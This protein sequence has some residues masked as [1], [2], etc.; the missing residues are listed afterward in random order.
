MAGPMADVAS[1]FPLDRQG[2]EDQ[3][4]RRPARRS[5]PA[6]VAD[7]LIDAVLAGRYL[8]G[9]TLPPERQL[10]EQ[11]GINRTSLRHAIARVEQAGL[12]EARQGVGTVVCD[13]LSASDNAIVLRALAVA[14]PRIVDEL[15]EIREPLAAVAGRLAATR[16]SSEDVVALGAHLDAVRWAR[17]PAALQATE[18]SFFSV[19]V[20][21][22]GNRPLQV[23]MRWLEELYDATAPLFVS[24]F[25][26][27]DEIAAGLEPIADAVR[28]RDAA[29]SGDAAARYAHWSGRRLL[30]AV[31]SG[32]DPGL[33]GAS[34]APGPTPQSP[35]IPGLRT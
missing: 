29:A 14:G 16:A 22:T 6:Q 26:S 25:T 9:T 5:L 1:G 3:T 13:P 4:L 21:A 7:V 24:A 30:D 18:L 8:P 33:S 12:V 32:R 19:L 31:R 23:L 27:A 2:L 15:L 35:L 11:L 17:H 34:S 10:A 20:G 28:A